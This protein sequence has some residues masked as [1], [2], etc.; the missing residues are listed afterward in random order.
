MCYVIDG[1]NLLYALGR[2]TKKSGQ[3]ALLSARRWLAQQLQAGHIPADALVVVFDGAQSPTFGI[4]SAGPIEFV[5][6]SSADDH[7]ED[8][9]SEE[10]QPAQL[11]IVSDDHRLHQAARR[12]GCA[13]LGCM[14]FWEQVQT[15]PRPAPQPRVTES[16]AKPERTSP[17]EVDR[18]LEVFSQPT[19]PLRRMPR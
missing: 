13:W 4:E 5:F 11:T 8:L 19:A 15:V 9:I 6:A 17:Q 18:W 10:K 2:L 1:Y 12:R 14:D 7:I 3:A 16:S